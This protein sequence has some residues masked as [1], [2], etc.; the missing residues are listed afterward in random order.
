MTDSVLTLREQRAAADLRALRIATYNIHG[1]VGTDG[2]TSPERIAGVIRELDADIVALQE[3]PLGG[4][5]APN[6]LPVL[7]EMTGMDAI[8]GPT[9]DTPGRRYGNA[10]LSRLP[11]CA[12]RSLDLSFGTREARGALDVDVET[13]GTG[14]PLRVVATHLGLSSRERRAQIRALI[15][16]FDTPRM[17]VLLMGDLN[18]WFVWGHALRMLVTHFRAAPAPRTFPSRLPVF[19]LDRIWMHP[20]DRLIDVT[21]HRS[22]RARVA[23]DHLPLVARIAREHHY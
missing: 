15:A 1:T 21:V 6:A 2:Q 17:P 22:T 12:T 3:V 18:E 13:D 10:I 9:L 23:S 7:R 20:A 8:A 11:I 14:S 4:S 19:A 16:A 5:F